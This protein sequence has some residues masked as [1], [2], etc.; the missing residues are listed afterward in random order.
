MSHL[1]LI[2]V[3]L[4]LLGFATLKLLKLAQY[5]RLRQLQAALVAEQGPRLGLPGALPQVLPGFEDR[6]AVVPHPVPDQTLAALRAAAE[7]R[8]GVERS[9][10]PTHKQGGT[11]AYEDLHRFAPEIIA[12]YQSDYLRRL[13]SSVVGAPVLPTPL[14]DQSS[15][16]LL[17]YEKPKDHIGWHYDHNFYNGRHFTVLLPLVNRD[18]TG[19]GLAAAELWA[20]LPEGDRRVP[21]P[22]NCLVVFEGAKILHKATRLGEGELRILLSMTFATDPS[23]TLAKGVARRFKDVAFYGVRALWT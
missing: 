14:H 5:R 6:L 19:D 15:C 8:G 16:S 22:A 2:P 13:V 10:V 18:A 12:F 23:A 21:T 1:I 20:R 9:F 4:L 7:R 3:A 11:V 17:V